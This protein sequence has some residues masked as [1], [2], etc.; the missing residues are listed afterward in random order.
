MNNA[1]LLIG[2][3]EDNRQYQLE[4]ARG[5]ISILCGEIIQQSAVYET[6]PWGKHDQP[7]FLNQALLI[8]TSLNARELMSSILSIEN[9]LGRKRTEKYGPRKIDI[10]ILFYNEEVIDLPGLQVPHPQLAQRR[11]ALEPMT[12][13]APFFVHPVLRKNM[14]ELLEACPDNLEVK[15]II[16]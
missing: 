2:G 5:K 4:Q 15:K 12:E 14:T 7:A 9:I 6:E 1:Y 8:R 10:D 3:N 13:I 16:G 11:F